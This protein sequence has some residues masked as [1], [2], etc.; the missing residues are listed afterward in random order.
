MAPSGTPSP[1]ILHPGNGHT[2]MRS[3]LQIT[4]SKE[5]GHKTTHFVSPHRNPKFCSVWVDGGA[6]KLSLI[7]FC[8]GFL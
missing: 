7:R 8:V 6:A 2:M 5:K 3:L 1:E 4:F